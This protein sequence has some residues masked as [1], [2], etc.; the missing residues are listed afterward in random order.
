[1]NNQNNSDFI[2][3]A[4]T[5]IEKSIQDFNE[6]IRSLSE[7]G[8]FKKARKTT[9]GFPIFNPA[10]DEFYQYA[11]YEKS[12]EWHI[13]DFLV[14]AILG[15]L[16]SISG[17]ECLWPDT[18]RTIHVRSSNESIEDIY[19]FEF[20]I[21]RDETRTGYRY[22]GLASN[23]V[24]KLINDYELDRIIILDWTDETAEHFGNAVIGCNSDKVYSESAK[25]F[26]TAFF[27]DELYRIY[28]SKVRKAVEN[29]N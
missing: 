19:P 16:F 25:H 14:N 3:N 15:S 23:E 11:Y 29:A 24:E 10:N 22:T 2:I 5:V 20:I 27:S 21:A 4:D 13:R 18:N 28:I 1:M 6:R 17:V 26:F 12:L 8:P 9:P 7:I